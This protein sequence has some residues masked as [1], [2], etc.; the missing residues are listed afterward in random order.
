MIEYQLKFKNQNLLIFNS[1]NLTNLSQVAK[2]NSVYIFI[3]Y[4]TQLN[5]DYMH[6]TAS[7]NTL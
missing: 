5:Y 6:T 3:L 7:I 4:G 1:M 2:L